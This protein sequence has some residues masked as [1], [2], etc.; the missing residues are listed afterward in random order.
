MLCSKC[1]DKVKSGAVS[2]TYL[3]IAK[4]L[5][6]KENRYQFLQDVALENVFE[7]GEYL[8]L[9]VGRGDLR[10]FESNP[11]AIKE[12]EDTFNRSLLVLESGVKDRQFLEDLFASQHIVTINIIWLP[13]GTTETRVLLRSRGSKRLSEERIKNLVDVAKKVKNMNLRVEYTQ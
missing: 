7:T 11:G 5:V 13:D 2:E 8:I 12:F 9:M 3:D 4:K 1:Q 10:R 6:E